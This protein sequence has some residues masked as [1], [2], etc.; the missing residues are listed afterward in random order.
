MTK[1]LN[2]RRQIVWGSDWRPLHEP[3]TWVA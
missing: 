2:P 1:K 3:F